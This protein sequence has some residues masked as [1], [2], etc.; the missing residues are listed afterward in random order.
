MACWDFA[1]GYTELIDQLGRVDL[2]H[3]L[4]V[5]LI[6]EHGLLLVLVTFCPRDEIP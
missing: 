3:I 1:W 6:H 5:N 4:S 2:L